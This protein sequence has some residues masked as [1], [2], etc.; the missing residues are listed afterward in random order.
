[1]RK[2]STWST[3]TWSPQASTSGT[4]PFRGM[5]WSWLNTSP[6]RVSN[7]RS[8][9]SFTSRAS[10]TSSMS[11]PPLTFQTPGETASISAGSAG[12]NSS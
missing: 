4:G 5:V 6:P 11:A 1:M 9:G 3:W 12:S 8:S 2:P 10:A 7:S